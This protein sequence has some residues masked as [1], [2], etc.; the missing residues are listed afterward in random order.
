MVS[1]KSN[2]KVD[3]KKTIATSKRF[4]VNAPAN[5]IYRLYKEKGNYYSLCRELLLKKKHT[6]MI[7]FA[8]SDKEAAQIKNWNDAD[9]SFVLLWEHKPNKYIKGKGKQQ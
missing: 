6:S 5:I 7:C 2:S 8:I 9:K 1:N 3:G 4:A